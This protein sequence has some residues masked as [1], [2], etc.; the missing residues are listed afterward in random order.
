ME[1]LAFHTINT[2]FLISQC[3]QTIVSM[4]AATVSSVEKLPT[5]KFLSLKIEFTI[6]SSVNEL[7]S[8]VS[9]LLCEKM[10]KSCT[11][12]LQIHCTV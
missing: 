9:A 1:E 2:F 4:V 11:N 6:N 3:E 10:M 7:R 8:S 12:H 5:E